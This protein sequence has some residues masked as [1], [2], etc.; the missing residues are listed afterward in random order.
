MKAN[1]IEFDTKKSV[2]RIVTILRSQVCQIDML[3]ADPFGSIGEP[4]P[5]VAV[6]LQGREGLFKNGVRWGVQ[7]I[8]YDLGNKRHIELIALGES[9]L[10][11]AFNS[12]A[13]N[14]LGSSYWLDAT[15]Y[16]NMGAGK[17]RRDR[18]AK[19]LA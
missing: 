11:A 14:G 2:Q 15:D 3:N 9:G 18:L 13:A 10:L 8:V 1:V 5:A 16:Y 12:Y 6:L 17:K 4:E 19:A 7:A